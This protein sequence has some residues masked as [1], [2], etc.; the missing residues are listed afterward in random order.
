VTVI[1]IQAIET[2]SVASEPFQFFASG[3]VLGAHD[4]AA[5]AND[6]PKIDKPGVFPLS[7][8]TYGP[9]FARLI[10]DIRSPELARAVGRKFGVDLEGLPLMITVRGQAQAKDGRIHTDTKD[11]VVTCLLY[12]ND[13][14]ENGGGR[15]RLLRNGDNL[16]D[17]AVEIPPNGGS[18]AAFKVS[19]KSWHG[20]KPFVGQRRYVMFNWVKSDA[21]LSRQIT[22]H[23]FSA[24]IKKLVP[25]F[26]KG[27]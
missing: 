10:D 12:L 1:D 23:K 22:R 19:D 18:F 24:T 26:Y 7:A 11:K 4:L 15:L 21:A 5:I 17:F 25:S 8:L 13:T 16:D 2:A 6:F 27:A 14:W 20:H 9:A 3:N